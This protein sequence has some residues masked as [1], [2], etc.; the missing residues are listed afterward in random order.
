MGHH[1]RVP[2]PGAH[3]ALS[4]IT[5]YGN[6][7]GMDF[8]T[9]KP[10]VGRYG[11]NW[12]LCRDGFFFSVIAG[13]TTYCRPRPDMTPREEG[14]SFLLYDAPFEYRGPYAC[15]EV[16]FPSARPEPWD[17]VWEYFAAS[18]DTW[19]CTYTYVPVPLV[20]HLV[21]QHG[22]IRSAS[23]TRPDISDEERALIRQ[24]PAAAAG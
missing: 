18:D 6:R 2:R 17:G 3:D 8:D 20:R 14:S 9:L 24:S 4:V 5:A 7:P 22:G 15:V 19:D 23:K 13:H 21:R 10:A 11:K 16:G 1:H 12:L